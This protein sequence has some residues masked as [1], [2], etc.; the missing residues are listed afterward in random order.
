M[1]LFEIKKR[2]KPET[3]LEVLNEKVFDITNMAN[4]LVHDVKHNQRC[5]G[6]LTAQKALEALHSYMSDI[7]HDYIL[8]HNLNNS[9]QHDYSDGGG[10]DRVQL[11]AFEPVLNTIEEEDEGI[12]QDPSEDKSSLSL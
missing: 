3:N 8:E 7:I 5:T 1:R 4:A 11:V 12:P 2:K 6:E 9:S 10:L